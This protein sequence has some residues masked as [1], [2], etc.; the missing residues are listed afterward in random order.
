MRAVSNFIYNK[1]CPYQIT[2]R[3]KGVNQLVDMGSEPNRHNYSRNSCFQLHS[4]PLT[5][6]STALWRQHRL[7]PAIKRSQREL[8]YR[9][10]LQVKV[11]YD[12]GRVW[13]V[14]QFV[15]HDVEKTLKTE[16]FLYL[17]S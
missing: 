1:P 13:H 15:C 8:Y 5:L 10:T 11:N 7:Q 2:T 12:C 4:L 6:K 9:K 14:L 3:S 16:H 17:F